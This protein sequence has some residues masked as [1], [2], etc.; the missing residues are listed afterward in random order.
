ML[1]R[2]GETINAKSMGEFVSGLKISDEN[3]RVLLSLTPENYS[4]LSSKLV[5]LI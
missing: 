1:F 2:S 3:K 4:G 5:D